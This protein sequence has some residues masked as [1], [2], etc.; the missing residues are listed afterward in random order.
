MSG[1][2]PHANADDA[3]ATAHIRALYTVSGPPGSGTSTASMLLAARLGCPRVDAGTLFRELAAEA[4][5][6]LEQFG[7]MAES[8]H[9]VDLQLDARM[10]EIA[11]TRGAC[12]VLEGR[13]TGVLLRRENIKCFST[14]IDAPEDVRATRIAE[15]DSIP[16]EAALERLRLR[17]ESERRRY[18]RIYGVNHDDSSLYDLAI[19]SSRLSPDEIVARILAA[20]PCVERGAR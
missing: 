13:L 18:S 6:T 5:V 20:A 14:W 15:R 11:R 10:I 2:V 16:V 1:P 19:D 7:Q 8:D 9:R 4:G 12:I 3:V 17:E